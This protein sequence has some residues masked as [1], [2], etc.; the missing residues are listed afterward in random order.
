MWE[1]VKILY[2]YYSILYKGLEHL[3]IL[4]VMAGPGTK[5][6]WILRDDT[7]TAPRNSNSTFIY[8]AFLNISTYPE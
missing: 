6:L 7:C 5:A 2:K 4:A 8:R 3:L 1:V